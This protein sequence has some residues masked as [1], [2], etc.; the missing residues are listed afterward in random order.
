MR[1]GKVVHKKPRKLAAP[2]RLQGAGFTHKHVPAAPWLLFWLL[3][4][5]VL[6]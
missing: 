2:A 4:L 6:H 5:G 1:H 3:V